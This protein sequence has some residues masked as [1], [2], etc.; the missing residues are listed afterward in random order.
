MAGGGASQQSPCT[1]TP[2]CSPRC[3]EGS[4]GGGVGITAGPRVHQGRERGKG[5][6][7]D[8]EAQ[9]GGASCPEAEQQWRAEPRW[10]QN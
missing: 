9:R 3:G 5:Q 2:G 10:V 7:P 8:Q 6:G 4:R 1:P